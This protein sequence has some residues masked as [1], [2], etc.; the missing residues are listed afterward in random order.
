MTVRNTI[1]VVDDHRILRECLGES[2][3]AATDFKVVG[4]AED[5]RSA[6]RLVGKL[7]PDLVLLDLSMP[8]FSGLETLRELNRRYPETK[9]LILTIHKTEEYFLEALEAGASGYVLKDSSRDELQLAMRYVLMGKKYLSPEIQAKM[10][11]AYLGEEKSSKPREC[12]GTLT[13]R[14]RQIL[15]LVAE[16]RTNNDM[17]GYLNISIKTVA[18]HRA[19]LM[20]K[21]DLHNASSL[22]AF[23]VTRGLLDR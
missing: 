10:V 1:V 7:H 14:E 6:I 12:W 3:S 18:K 16:G 9:V 19:N 8:G 2:I 20:K 5:G 21:L 17:S 4:E 22:T 13:H 11:S 23:A 15:K